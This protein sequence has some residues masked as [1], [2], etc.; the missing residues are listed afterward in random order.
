MAARQPCPPTH[1]PMKMWETQIRLFKPGLIG[2]SRGPANPA[3]PLG[4]HCREHPSV[5]TTPS[6]PSFPSLPN[7]HMG[8]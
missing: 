5:G 7:T 4:Q 2:L 6:C 1:S 3:L 8:T